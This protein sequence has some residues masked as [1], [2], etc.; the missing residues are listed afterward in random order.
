MDLSIVVPVF[1]EAENIH[2]LV[3]EI[4]DV[5]GDRPYFEVIVVDDGSTDATAA[6]LARCRET[7]KSLRV[8]RHQACTGQSAAIISGVTAAKSSLIATLDGDGQNDPADL[9]GLLAHYRDAPADVTLVTGHRKHRHDSLLKRISSRVANR[10]R[11]TILGDNTPD[12]GC[13]MKVFSREQFLAL[14]QFDHMHRFL[15]ALFQRQG[16]QVMSIEISH[17]PRLKGQSKY[18]VHNRLWAGIVDMLGVRWLQRRRKRPV[19]S[20]LE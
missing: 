19:V 14:P 18:G 12:T 10:V 3:D 2:S 6:V 20:E 17:R 15:P 13:G 4:V 11:A 9:P 16:G 5:L 8:L 7:V 1:N